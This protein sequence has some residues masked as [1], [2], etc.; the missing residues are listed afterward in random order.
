M[1]V[2]AI[3]KM[4]LFEFIG[5]ARLILG[6]LEYLPPS[7]MSRSGILASHDEIAGVGAAFIISAKP[8]FAI[9]CVAIF[10]IDTIILTEHRQNDQ[11]LFADQSQVPAFPSRRRLQP[12]AMAGC[13]GG[14]EGRPAVAEACPL[15][16]DV[17]RHLR[18]G[19]T[20]TPRRPVH[21]RLA[22]P[23]AGRSREEWRIR[24]S[25]HTKRRASGGG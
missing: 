13:A 6:T 5:T 23:G 10:H 9:G 19:R 17:G 15:Q 18:M 2:Q 11:A 21:F 12:R 16:C 25:R 22:R 7:A 8:C 24:D 4:L 20:G 3:R 14:A 1:V